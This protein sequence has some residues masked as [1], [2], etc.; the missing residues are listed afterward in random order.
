MKIGD[1]IITLVESKGWQLV[2]TR[3]SHRQYRH[4]VHLGTVTIAGQ[5]G[6]DI[7]RDV[8]SSILKQAGITRKDLR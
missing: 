3:G 6:T 2:R 8:I 1:I 7:S 5:L 4:P